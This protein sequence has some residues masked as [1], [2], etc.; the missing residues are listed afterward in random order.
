MSMDTSCESKHILCKINFSKSK[1]PQVYENPLL[2]ILNFLQFGFMV[3]S[4]S[5]VEHTFCICGPARTMLYFTPQ[6]NM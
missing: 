4:N 5:L 2:K 1:F 6:I 3:D